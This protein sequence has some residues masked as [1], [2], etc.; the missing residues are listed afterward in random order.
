[1]ILAGLSVASDQ[2][3]ANETGRQ[4]PLKAGKALCNVL[5]TEPM[6]TD[7]APEAVATGGDVAGPSAS[8]GQPPKAAKAATAAKAKAGNSRAA[9]RESSATAKQAALKETKFVNA[10]RER[11]YDKID[12]DAD[13]DC[14]YHGLS[15]FLS[16]DGRHISALECRQAVA[17]EMTVNRSSYEDFWD[18]QEDEGVVS[19]EDYVA[20]LRMPMEV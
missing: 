13:G 18:P 2:L 6:G 14:L 15:K 4:S 1:M 17:D 8:S 20:L 3:M 7:T 19:Y 9:F 5:A 12:M 10:L 16:V 11:G